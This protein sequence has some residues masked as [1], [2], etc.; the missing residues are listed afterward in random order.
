MVVS[1][2]VS[3]A[4]Q[5][6]ESIDDDLVAIHRSGCRLRPTRPWPERIIMSPLHPRNSR[7]SCAESKVRIAM[8]TYRDCRQRGSTTP[9]N[10]VEPWRGAGDVAGNQPDS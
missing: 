1:Y 4:R 10:D 8:P 7:R 6:I 2:E 5:A 3:A 9:R